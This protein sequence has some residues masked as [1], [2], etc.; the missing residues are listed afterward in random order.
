MAAVLGMVFFGRIL[1]RS[2]YMADPQKR[3]AGMIAGLLANIA[4]VLTAFWGVLS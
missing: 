2:D 3:A 4:L 1:Y